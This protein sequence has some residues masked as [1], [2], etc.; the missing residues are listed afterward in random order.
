[1]PLMI[2]VPREIFPG[3]KRVA[4]VPEVVGKLTRLGFG[5]SIESGAGVAADFGDEA[6]RAAGAQIVPDA[7]GLWAA[8]DVVFKVGTDAVDVAAGFQLQH[9]QN[10]PPRL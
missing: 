3:E 7:A 6:Y 9:V 2:G 4:T 5:V 10:P 1:M 8:A